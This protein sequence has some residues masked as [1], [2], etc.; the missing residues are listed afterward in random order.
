[1]FSESVKL[2]VK[3][4]TQLSLCES[5]R[6]DRR[7]IHRLVNSSAKVGR[8][9]GWGGGGDGG[10]VYGKYESWLKSWAIFLVRGGLA[11]QLG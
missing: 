4:L 9:L 2:R 10:V 8:W 6:G 7:A 11:W 1:M 3:E 5:A